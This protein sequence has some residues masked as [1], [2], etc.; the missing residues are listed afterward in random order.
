MIKVSDRVKQ[1]E[2]ARKNQA[3]VGANAMP[4]QMAG[5]VPHHRNAYPGGVQVQ[6]QAPHLPV[7]VHVQA[8]QAQPQPPLPMVPLP[9]MYVCRYPVAA[10]PPVYHDPM[11]A[12]QYGGQ[13]NPNG[14]PPMAQPYQ[15][16]HYGPFV[17]YCPYCY[18]YH[19]PNQ[20]C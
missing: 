9:L 5:N 4:Y 17:P 19:L 14:M 13:L 2:D 12:L 3:V 15:Q 20:R 11:Y 7:R 1:A 8:Q 18:R 16:A 6:V 10:P